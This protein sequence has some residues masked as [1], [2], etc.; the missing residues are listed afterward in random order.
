[1]SRANCTPPWSKSGDDLALR[2]G[3]AEDLP[4]R[5]LGV[6]LLLPA[7][8]DDRLG[9]DRSRGRDGG[10]RVRSAAGAGRAAHPA[11]APAAVTSAARAARRRRREGR[12]T[13]VGIV[14]AS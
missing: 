8:R 6:L 2:V 9:V 11:T 12:R 13:V 3:R 4:E 1:M 14:G 7:A 10:G 5:G